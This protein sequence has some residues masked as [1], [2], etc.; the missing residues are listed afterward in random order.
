MWTYFTKFRDET[1]ARR[2]MEDLKKKMFDES[3]SNTEQRWTFYRSS[4]FHFWILWV[5]PIHPRNQTHLYHNYTFRGPRSVLPIKWWFMCDDISDSKQIWRHPQRNIRQVQR[6]A[7]DRH[8]I[9]PQQ[10]RLQDGRQRRVYGGRQK[11]RGCWQIWTSFVSEWSR[12]DRTDHLWFFIKIRI[13][14]GP[15]SFDLSWILFFKVRILRSF[16]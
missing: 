11:G 16:K 15:K 3:N 10:R 14:P 5:I 2:T 4:F 7:R 9:R 13:K 8:S 6:E 12:R 1:T